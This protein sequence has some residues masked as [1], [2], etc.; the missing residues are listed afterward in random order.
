MQRSMYNGVMRLGM[1]YEVL[2]ETPC[3]SEVIGMIVHICTSMH[4]QTFLL[5]NIQKS[6]QHFMLYIVIACTLFLLFLYWQIPLFFYLIVQK[7]NNMVMV[8]A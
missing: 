6:K 7:F 5:R 2:S 8:Y 3:R 4:F 1:Y